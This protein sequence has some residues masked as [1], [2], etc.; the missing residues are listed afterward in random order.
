MKIYAPILLALTTAALTQSAMAEGLL[1]QG[2]KAICFD[3]KGMLYE[4]VCCQEKDSDSA[5]VF[6]NWEQYNTDDKSKTVNSTLTCKVDYTILQSVCKQHD[7]TVASNCPVNLQSTES[8]DN[9][10]G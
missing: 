1:Y 7:G 4:Q 8:V 10:K 9:Y 3:N 6:F 5:A 2:A